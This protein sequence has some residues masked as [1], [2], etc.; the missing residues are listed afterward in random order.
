MSLLS[1]KCEDVST[2]YTQDLR[3]TS[4]LRLNEAEGES[5]VPIVEEQLLMMLPSLRSLLKRVSR[6][7]AEQLFSA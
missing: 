6:V 3:S 7:A 4:E 5:V 1:D 2:S